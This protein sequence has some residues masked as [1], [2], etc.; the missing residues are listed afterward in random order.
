[1]PD[2]PDYLLPHKWTYLYDVTPLKRTLKQYIDFDQLK[3]IFNIE[4]TK[5]KC[6]WRQPNETVSNEDFDLPFKASENYLRRQLSD[7]F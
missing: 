6:N 2:S 7:A 4:D 5:L 1:M 3:K